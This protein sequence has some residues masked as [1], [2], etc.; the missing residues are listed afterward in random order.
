MLYKITIGQQVDINSYKKDNKGDKLTIFHCILLCLQ[1]AVFS[2]TYLST[3][4]LFW[5]QIRIWMTLFIIHSPFKEF[6]KVS[7]SFNFCYSG[8][9]LFCNTISIWYCIINILCHKL[10]Q[11]THYQFVYNC[12]NGWICYLQEWSPISQHLSANYNL[13]HGVLKLQ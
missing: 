8:K 12:S 11:N 10:I 1:Y 9:I 13:D 5:P 3:Q 4:H 2:A 7:Y 6:I